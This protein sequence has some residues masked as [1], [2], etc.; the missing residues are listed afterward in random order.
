MPSILDI[1][2]D[3]ALFKKVP[4]TNIKKQYYKNQSTSN[5]NSERMIQTKKRN[6]P[7]VV[8]TVNAFDK[9]STSKVTKTFQN[10]EPN[11]YKG[12]IDIRCISAYDIKE[13][14]NRVISR[15]KQKNIFYVQTSLYK[16]RC[17]KQLTSFDIELCLIDNG[18]CYYIVKIKS[19]GF[20]AN[21][22]IISHLFN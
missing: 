16:L 19:G 6:I 21:V 4:I 20:N 5:I 17:S 13:S 10:E 2:D 7:K 14:L 8:N 9:V 22:D 18:L 12:M 11:H 1:N 15:L 3:D